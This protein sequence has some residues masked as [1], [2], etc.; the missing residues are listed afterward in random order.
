VI[1]LEAL[2]AEIRA[3]LRAEI[4]ELRDDAPAPGGVTE[5]MVRSINAPGVYTLVAD[6][7]AKE[8]VPGMPAQ[9]IAIEIRVG[10]ITDNAR[11]LSAPLVGPEGQYQLRQ[12]VKKALHFWSPTSTKR[13]LK[14]ESYV[15]AGRVG[16]R[17][18]GDSTFISSIYENYS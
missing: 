10:L 6:R 3:R 12:R 17:S 1:D 11:T 5:E 13:R 2:D 14:F 8:K 15:L 18:C 7:N 16:S 9:D 4:P